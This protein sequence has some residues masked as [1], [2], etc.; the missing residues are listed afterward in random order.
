MSGKLIFFILA[1]LSFLLLLRF[2]NFYSGVREYP[3]D[4]IVTWQTRVTANPKLKINGQQVSLFLPNSQRVLVRFSLLP[5]LSYGDR[6]NVRGEV[7]Y[8]TA[9]PTGR[10]AENGKSVAY[11]SYPEFEIVER[12]RD[13]NPILRFREETIDFFN[14]SL[15]QN[16][17]SLM[18]GIVFGIKEEMAPGFYLDLQKQG[19]CMWSLLQV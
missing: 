13:I 12:G 2:I 3:E 4:T 15:P 7:E 8:F 5:Q 16:Y 17:S 11:M 10:Q 14:T 9:M 1:L 6:I 19:L 18:L